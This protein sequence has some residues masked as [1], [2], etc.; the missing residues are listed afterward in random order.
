MKR[1]T[2]FALIFLMVIWNLPSKGQ[3]IA[4]ELK[5]TLKEAQDYAL[6][7]NRTVLSARADVKASRMALW[8]TIS[9]GLPQIEASGSFAD[10][11]KL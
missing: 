7:N 5:L 3:E 10:N 6:E 4:G 2:I 11:L 9:A 1:K 8:E